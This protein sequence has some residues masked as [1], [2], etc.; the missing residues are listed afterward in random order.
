[1]LDFKGFEVEAL[2]ALGRTKEAEAALQNLPT[3]AHRALSLSPATVMFHAVQELRIHG[4]TEASRALAAKLWAIRLDQSPEQQKFGR[5]RAG[6]LLLYM[7]RDAEALE[8]F[9]TLATEDPR[10]VDF[11]ANAGAILARLGKVEEARKVDAVL[12]AL[13]RP[14]LFGD[15]A[16]G[17]AIIAAQ[18]GE[19]DRAVN[20]LREALAHGG[21]L[22]VHRE[23]FLEPLHGYPPYEEM[24]RPKG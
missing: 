15:D 6:M 5:D 8:I 12:G 24:V 13:N 2:V 11:Q 17:R 20:Y 23:F 21:F 1:M 22:A 4:H 14:Y 18:L 10:S 9:R 19:K 3:L 16:F 7:G